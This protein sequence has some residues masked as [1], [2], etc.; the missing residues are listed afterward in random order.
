MTVSPRRTSEI[1]SCICKKYNQAQNYTAFGCRTLTSSR[2]CARRY[3]DHRMNENLIIEPINVAGATFLV[4]F[5]ILAIM[6]IG[7]YMANSALDAIDT[8]KHIG[9]NKNNLAPIRLTSVLMGF[10]LT[11][12]A[13]FISES[14][15]KIWGP[16]FQGIGISTIST[17]AAVFFVFIVNL[18]IIT[19]LIW[20]SGGVQSSPFTAVLFML[21]ALAIF[22]RLQSYVFIICTVYAA[23]AYLII[24]YLHEDRAR[25]KGRHAN[26]VVNTLCL[27]LTAL[28]G[29]ITRPVPIG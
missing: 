19:Y 9:H 21:P 24:L 16:L 5:C 12:P 18:I 8:S 27:V 3:R 22:L 26:A 29:F 14:F 15:F 23:L 10:L 6:I 7:I 17:H 4:Q 1:I 2:R 13:L 11:F 25:L 20:L 28:I